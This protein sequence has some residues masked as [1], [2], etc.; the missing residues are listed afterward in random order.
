MSSCLLGNP[1]GSSG[2]HKRCPYLTGV[3]GKYFEWIPICPVVEVGLG[4]PRDTLRLVEDEKQS[5]KIRLVLGKSQEDLTSH[6]VEYARK[7]VEQIMEFQLHGFILKKDSPLCEMERVKIYNT[8][9]MSE[10]KGYGMFAK[11]LMER[12][13]E[14]PIEEEERLTDPGLRENFIERVFA[15]YRWK[16]L[17]QSNPS[18]RDLVRFHTQHKMAL[19]SHS[20]D[21]YTR[22]G[23]WISQIGKVNKDE[24]MIRYGRLFMEALSFPAT[25]KT[26][27]NVLYHLIGFLKKEMTSLDQEELVQVIEEYRLGLIPLI[28]PIT[29]LN[30]HFRHHPSPWVSEQ[31]YL[32]PNPLELKLRNH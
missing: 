3:L 23:Q 14:L 32:H 26:H 5:G 20:R 2:G 15:Y 10:R 28:V 27:T 11:E 9:G 24:W 6:M 21:Y 4:T 13:P 31:T 17:I 19:L 16:C 12:V 29:L 18:K 30:H 25:R 1:V 22:L 7:R 8:H